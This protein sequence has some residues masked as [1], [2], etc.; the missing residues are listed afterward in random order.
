M[1]G[2]PASDPDHR[3]YERIFENASDGIMTV[4]PDDEES[5]RYTEANPSACEMLGLNR[6]QLVDKHLDEI[7]DSEM[8][9]YLKEIYAR[10][11][12][13][14]EPEEITHTIQTPG[15]KLVS[16]SRLEPV[17]KPNGKTEILIVARDI[18]ALAETQE[19]LESDRQAF[20]DLYEVAGAS[21]LEHD[22]QMR[23]L[24][25]IGCDRLNLPFGFVTEIDEGIQEII[26]AVG[27]HPK[28]QSG[29]EAPLKKSYCRKTIADE[30]RLVAIVDAIEEGWARDPAYEK[31]DL[32]CYLGAKLVVN[33]ELSGT[34]CFADRAG[35]AHQFDDSEQNFMRLLAQWISRTAEQNVLTNKL[36]NL[37]ETDGLTGLKDRETILDRIREEQER[38]RRY[39]HDLCILMLDLDHF[40]SINDEYGHWTGDEVLRNVAELLREQTRIPDTVG[41]YG[42]EEFIIVAPNMTLEDAETLGERIRNA[43]QQSSMTSEEPSLNV[44]CSIGVNAVS[45]DGASIDQAVK[46]ADK[47][48]YE[49]K[50]RGR[51]RVVTAS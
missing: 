16:R 18:T 40:K 17:E 47:A 8:A 5:F 9:E 6:S 38:A 39:K 19:K 27:D 29:N 37:A 1:T 48:M 41:R 34:V 11:L 46:R 44:T 13:A 35:R 3:I 26:H 31:Y 4:E 42:G 50:K 10:V 23:R 49:A 36:A 51:N 20:R 24:L 32:G 43:I 45:T 22:E 30:N 15:G 14:G 12:E 2:S 7:F 25:S 21:G 33:G 28:L